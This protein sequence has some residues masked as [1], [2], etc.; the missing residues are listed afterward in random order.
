MGLSVAAATVAVQVRVAVHGE[1]QAKLLTT[2]F[3]STSNWFWPTF[4]LA[5][6]LS[7]SICFVTASFSYD[8]ACLSFGC[9]LLTAA[10]DAAQNNF[11]R[12]LVGYIEIFRPN[13]IAFLTI[14]RWCNIWRPHFSTM[15]RIVA[16]LVLYLSLCIFL[17]ACLVGSS[18]QGHV[19]NSSNQCMG[20]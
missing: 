16:F 19:W 12:H 17:T 7:L 3:M 14:S 18:W 13:F 2:I 11:E 8:V 6:W 15:F 5:F 20:G 4:D 9:V 10:T 1:D